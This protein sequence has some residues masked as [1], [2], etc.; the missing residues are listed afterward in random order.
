MRIWIVQRKRCMLNCESVVASSFVE[1]RVVVMEIEGTNYWMS[2]GSWALH[3]RT[4]A[5]IHNNEIS[6]IYHTSLHLLPNNSRDHLST[7]NEN[8]R[9]EIVHYK[10][11]CTGEGSC[12][13]DILNRRTNFQ[14][15]Q[16]CPSITT[17]DLL[18]CPLR[19]STNALGF[20][21]KS[22]PSDRT[23]VWEVTAEPKRA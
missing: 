15:Y 9:K 21:F 16:T 18:Q 22:T 5:R 12:G 7:L 14:C 11:P 17:R 23:L 1:R 20:H 6:E 2:S 8:I 3:I 4:I 13:T 19:T 10:P